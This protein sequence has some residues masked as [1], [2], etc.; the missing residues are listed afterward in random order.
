VTRYL[1]DTNAVLIGLSTPALLT[2]AVRDAML[3]GRN[4]VSVLSYWEVQLKS[5]KG[6]LD[7]G[8]PRLWWLDALD[9]LTATVVLLRPEHISAIRELPPVHQ[10]PFDRALM[11]QAMV[12][13]LTF[14]TLD[15]EIPKYTSDRLRVLA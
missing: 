1:L 11:A 2:A 8:D 9:K 6:K 7:V 14:V 13:N 5:V 12:E 10:D 15:A 4:A 3:S